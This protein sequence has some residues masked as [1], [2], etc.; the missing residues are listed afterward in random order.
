ML[1]QLRDVPQG[2]P[3]ASALAV[4]GHTVT[5]DGPADVVVMGIPGSA[6]EPD[7][8][9]GRLLAATF[10]VY[11]ALL[12]SPASAVVLLGSLRV[13]DG[14]DAAWRLSESWAPRPTPDL[15]SLGP[16]LAELTA[17]EMSREGGL[18]V[19]LLRLD[20]I[21]DDV[22]QPGVLAEDAAG[23]V[24]EAVTRLG[25]LAGSAPTGQQPSYLELNVTGDTVRFA[26]DATLRAPFGWAPAHPTAT[27]AEMRSPLWPQGGEPLSVAG[28]PGRVTVYGAGGPMGVAVCEVLAETVQVT[29]TD[30]DSLSALALR[31]AQSVGAPVPVPM[32]APHRERVVDVTDYEQ[33]LEA[34]RGSDCLVNVTVVRDNPALAFQVNTLGAW[35]IVRAA[36][37]LG[38]PRVVQ[39]APTLALQGDPVGMVF[40]RAVSADA[41]GRPGRWVYALS[42]LLGLEAGRV[43]AEHERLAV[44]QLLFNQL[45]PSDAQGKVVVGYTVSWR[46][47]GRAIAAATRVQDWPEPSPRMDVLA[48]NPHGRTRWQRTW[49]LLGIEPEDDFEAAWSVS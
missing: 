28:E 5:D 31:P 36:A 11:E 27:R 12:T 17:R 20:N 49:R 15:A 32:A 7:S 22:S 2:L 9:A 41:P 42:K 39:T 23:A 21:V 13:Y 14:Y 37:Q 38:I 26:P 29:A 8:D 24:T 16:Y 45:L 10:G 6:V 43:I 4:A 34:A 44:P 46:D 47:A 18:R 3:L 1:V 30:R 33:V 48:P 25:A 35:N 40:D 19:W